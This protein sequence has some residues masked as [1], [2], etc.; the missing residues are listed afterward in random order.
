M[1]DV[2]S[3]N[4]LPYIPA[5]SDVTDMMAHGQQQ[6]QQMLNHQTATN[7][8]SNLMGLSSMD[9]MHQSNQSPPTHP[10]HHQQQQQQS[11]NIKQDYGL[12]SL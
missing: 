9:S 3:L 12:T 4:N 11:M 1:A 8:G 5:A 6:S 7:N 2:T 10:H